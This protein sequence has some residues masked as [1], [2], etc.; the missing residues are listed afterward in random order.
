MVAFEFSIKF[1][2]EQLLIPTCFGVQILC[3]TSEVTCV[4]ARLVLIF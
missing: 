1:Y 2:D 4:F 3:I